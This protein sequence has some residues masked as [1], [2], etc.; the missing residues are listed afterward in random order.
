MSDSLNRIDSSWYG[1][2]SPGVT[3]LGTE[4][5]SFRGESAPGD[6]GRS[7]F[8]LGETIGVK[9]GNGDGHAIFSSASASSS[10]RRVVADDPRLPRRYGISAEMSIAYERTPPTT[11]QIG[12]AHV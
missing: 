6:N 9:T 12:R 11:T 8:G 10:R 1:E 5:E 2:N 4:L 7:S 3:G